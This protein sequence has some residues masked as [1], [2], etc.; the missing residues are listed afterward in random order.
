MIM[1]YLYR[2]AI[3]LFVT[4]LTACATVRNDDA[5]VR[6]LVLRLVRS[7]NAANVDDFVA[8]FDA[9]ATAFFPSSANAT[10]K[11]G[12]EAIR[13]AVT[14]TFSQGPPATRIV[15]RDLTISADRNVAYASFDGGNG[16]MHARRTL[17]LR[18]TRNAWAIV[19]LHASNV[20]E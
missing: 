8:C 5:E 12:R 17:I 10:R 6:E 11:V 2:L 15:P 13:A 1:S 16:A 18:K 4:A 20:S 3:V 9:N 14:P 19:H 7:V